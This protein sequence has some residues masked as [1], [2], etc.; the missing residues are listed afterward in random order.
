MAGTKVPFRLLV[1]ALQGMLQ[2]RGIA[3]NDPQMIGGGYP[4]YKLWLSAH[5]TGDT[6]TAGIWAVCSKLLTF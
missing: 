5:M 4:C 1:I 3:E 6:L 2:S